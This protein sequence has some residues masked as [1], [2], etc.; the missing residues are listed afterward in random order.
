MGISGVTILGIVES[1]SSVASSITYACSN[2]VTYFV[3]RHLGRDEF[4]EAEKHAYALRGFHTICG[5]IS[6]VLMI[7]IIYVIAYLPSSAKGV[8]EYIGGYFANN[9][10]A[11]IDVGNN[12]TIVK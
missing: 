3:A 10:N 6:S 4:E 8:Q 11:S 2:N 1:L 9:N 5:I 12:G 7:G